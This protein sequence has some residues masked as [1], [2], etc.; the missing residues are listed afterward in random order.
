MEVEA[1]GEHDACKSL[2]VQFRRCEGYLP[3]VPQP[4]SSNWPFAAHANINPPCTFHQ[5]GLRALDCAGFAGVG[6]TCC[7]ACSCLQYSQK[8]QQMVKRANDGEISKTLNA[9]GMGI[10]TTIYKR[11]AAMC[12]I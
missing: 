1:E 4:F 6:A 3:P 7:D 8:V 2:V 11:N 10:T 5:S 12:S 9:R